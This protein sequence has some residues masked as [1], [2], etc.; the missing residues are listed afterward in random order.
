MIFQLP[1]PGG[2]DAFRGGVTCKIAI[3]SHNLEVGVQGSVADVNVR[4]LLIL[5][6]LALVAVGVFLALQPAPTLPEDNQDGVPSTWTPVTILG[7]LAFLAGVVSMVL[8]LIVPTRWTVPGPV[9]APEPAP[10]APL[11]PMEPIA[12]P[13]SDVEAA[14]VRLLDEGERVLYLR[15]RDA[16][17]EV[18]Q[19][20]VVG[21]GTFSPAKVTRLLDRL[22]AKGLVV[23]ERHGA[24]N[25]L[26]LTHRPEI[27]EK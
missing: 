21:W 24:T 12:R 4:R 17:G 13:S 8:G 26:R 9:T 18:L 25:R 11:N 2:F 15:L 27:S 22:E 14:V 23:R 1:H 7:I 20:D 10:V 3:P 19:R 5:G 16:G 6:A